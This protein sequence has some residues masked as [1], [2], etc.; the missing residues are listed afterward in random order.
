MTDSKQN[1]GDY[2]RTDLTPLLRFYLACIEEEDKRSLQVSAEPKFGQFIIPPGEPGALLKGET[3][4]SWVPT[5]QELR[6]VKRYFFESQKQRFIYGFPLKLDNRANISPLF[7][8]EA[9]MTLSDDQKKIEIHLT[10]PGNIQVN[11]HLFSW[12]H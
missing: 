2:L 12:T 11:L 10:H 4:I 3:E 1:D 7:F 9:E 5:D 6:F 8:T